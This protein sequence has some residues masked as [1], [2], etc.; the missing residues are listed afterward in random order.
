MNEGSNLNVAVV[1]GD[2]RQRLVAD[3]LTRRGYKVS[4][5]AVSGEAPRADLSLALAEADLLVLPLPASRDG[6]YVNA[7][8]EIRFDTM[9]NCLPRGCKVFAGKLQPS[10]KDLLS[11]RGFDVF[12]FYED[13]LFEQEN[14]EISADG[15]IDYLASILNV[16]I[17][18]KSF[19]VCGYGRFGKALAQKLKALGAFV[20]VAARREES[21]AA[22][23]GNGLSALKIDLAQKSF[24]S[25]PSRVCAVL[26]TV[27]YHIFNEENMWTLKDKIYLELASAPFGGEPAR[28]RD[29]AHYS[30]LPAIP[31]KFAPERAGR[32]MLASLLR[33]IDGNFSDGK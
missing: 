12:D 7:H 15:A 14:T 23:Q 4:E 16:R 26:N 29:A 30:Y 32:A 22:A 33:Y 27:P 1:G 25:V 21:L 8:T 24:F 13:E 2:S 28:L 17:A 9:V 10:L 11:G 18:G 31:A 6:F 20:T 3:E 19:L 5:Y